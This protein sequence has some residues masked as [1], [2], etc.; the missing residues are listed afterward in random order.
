MEIT[1]IKNM[2]P[3]M[4]N[5]FDRLISRLDTIEKKISEVEN[6]VIKLI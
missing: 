1:K 5:F 3:E 6:R 2:V 4:K